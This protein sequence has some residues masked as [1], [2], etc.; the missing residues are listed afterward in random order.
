MNLHEIEETLLR[1]GMRKH[2]RLKY[3]STDAT[4]SD[5]AY[6]GCWE[7]QGIFVNDEDAADLLVMHALR[8]INGGPR[9]N[10]GCATDGDAMTVLRWIVGVTAHL[11]PK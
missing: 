11:E 9:M 10:H 6:A 3:V 5:W 2:P 8:W 7:M 1:R 4:G